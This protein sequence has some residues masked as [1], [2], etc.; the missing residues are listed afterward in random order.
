M[1]EPESADKGQVPRDQKTPSHPRATVSRR[2][3]T[4]T[5]FTATTPA[6]RS[7]RRPIRGGPGTV[8]LNMF[9]F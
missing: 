6:R 9:I 2:E 4:T 5:P 8:I 1:T 3:A 7:L